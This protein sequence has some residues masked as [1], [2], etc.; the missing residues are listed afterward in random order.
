MNGQDMRPCDSRRT[1]ASGQQWPAH[2]TATNWAQLYNSHLLPIAPPGLHSSHLLHSQEDSPGCFPV[3][4]LQCQLWA[5]AEQDEP[6]TATLHNSS[7]SAAQSITSTSAG[8]R[9]ADVAAAP[10]IPYVSGSSTAL[11]VPLH[12]RRWQRCEPPHPA[13]FPPSPS[14]ETPPRTAPTAQRKGRQGEGG[15]RKA[16]PSSGAPEQ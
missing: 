4:T 16:R 1:N 14:P 6:S 8:Q 12:R 7:G 9:P 10:P 11:I 2:G 13:Q 3:A 5:M 15:R